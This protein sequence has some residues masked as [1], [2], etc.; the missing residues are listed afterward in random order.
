MP[1]P[2]TLSTCTFSSTTWWRWC[3]ALRKVCSIKPRRCVPEFRQKMAEIY[4]VLSLNGPK[5]TQHTITYCTFHIFS[6]WQKKES[7]KKLGGTFIQFIQSLQCQVSFRQGTDAL[8][9]KATKAASKM[10]AEVSSSTEPFE[11]KSENGLIIVLYTKNIKK[12]F[13]N[14]CFF[15]IRWESLTTSPL[16]RSKVVSASASQ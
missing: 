9:D 10:G 2:Q 14:E 4:P 15:F 6:Y 13:Y 8:S 12:W 5:M 11:L 16:G 3:R 7:P 1:G